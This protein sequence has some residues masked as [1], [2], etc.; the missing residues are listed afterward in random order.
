MQDWDMDRL[1]KF[2]GTLDQFGGL[3]EG[4]DTHVS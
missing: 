3:Q 2:C 1:A 4:E